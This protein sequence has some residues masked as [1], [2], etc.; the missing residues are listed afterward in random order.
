MISLSLSPSLLLQIFFLI[1][2]IQA[3]VHWSVT[4]SRSS[5][6]GRSDS[7]TTSSQTFQDWRTQ[8]LL[9]L[10]SRHVWP[11]STSPSTRFDTSTQYALYHL[12]LAEQFVCNCKVCIPQDL[13]CHSLSLS[14]RSSLNLKSYVCCISMAIILVS[15]QKWINLP[16]CRLSIPSLCTATP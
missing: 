2:L 10:P 8:S 15:C 11:G 4:R 6:A 14:V 3:L 1:C 16:C 7:A 13:K 5:S 12:S 9:C